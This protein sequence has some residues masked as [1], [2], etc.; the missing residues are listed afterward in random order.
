[1]ELIVGCFEQKRI[2]L[3]LLMVITIYQVDVRMLMIFVKMSWVL[4][5]NYFFNKIDVVVVLDLKIDEEK[6]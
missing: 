3:L 6:Y 4:L 2:N 5:K 1:M